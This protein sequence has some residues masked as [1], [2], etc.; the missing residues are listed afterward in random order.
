VDVVVWL[1]VRSIHSWLF[2]STSGIALLW[3]SLLQYMT[4]T[5]RRSGDNARRDVRSVGCWGIDRRST[6]RVS[7]R[8]DDRSSP[9][10]IC[11]RN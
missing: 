2:T 8:R 11:S 4:P 9:S 6:R 10:T 5:A 7:L 3:F 1:I